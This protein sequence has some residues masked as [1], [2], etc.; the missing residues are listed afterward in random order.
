[1]SNALDKKK[2]K[3]LTE[4]I[5]LALLE[6]MKTWRDYKDGITLLC[7]YNPKTSHIVIE[8]I[9]IPVALRRQGLCGDILDE[10][11]IIASAYEKEIWLE[12]VDFFGTS[13]K[14]LSDMY[15]SYGFRWVDKQWMKCIVN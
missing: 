12:P 2:Q 3:A 13:I 15:T 5:N 9:R 4:E 7:F 1:M 11:K 6:V 14:V 8:L 10:I